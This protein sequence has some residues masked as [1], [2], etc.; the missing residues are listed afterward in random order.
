MT[1]GKKKRWQ[2]AGR[3]R[4]CVWLA[5]AAGDSARSGSGIGNQEAGAARSSVRSR[6]RGTVPRE[7]K[8]L[9]PTRLPLPKP[10]TGNLPPKSFGRPTRR[11]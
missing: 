1:M 7:A 6:R 8:T 9:R 11:A 5:F 10:L 3:F 2:F 4:R